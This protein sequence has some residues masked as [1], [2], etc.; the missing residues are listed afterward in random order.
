MF[1]FVFREER[2][3]LIRNLRNA[4]MHEVAYNLIQ[5][6]IRRS[7]RRVRELEETVMRLDDEG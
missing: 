1:Y 6:K 7:H 5:R 4:P 3:E 2:F